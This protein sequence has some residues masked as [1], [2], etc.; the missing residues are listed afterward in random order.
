MIDKNQILKLVKTTKAELEALVEATSKYIKAFKEFHDN[1]L[2]LSIEEAD[3]LK[4]FVLDEGIVETKEIKA[5][6][7][8][9]ISFN[10]IHREIEK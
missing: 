7:N 9:V 6:E 10:K 2:C 8:K 4:Y 3:L 5:L 1:H